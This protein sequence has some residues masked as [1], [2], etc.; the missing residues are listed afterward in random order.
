MS[1]R[2]ATPVGA[3]RK[4][5]NVGPVIVYRAFHYLYNSYYLYFNNYIPVVVVVVAVAVI[6]TINSIDQIQPQLL[7]IAQ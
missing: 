7:A 4:R 1:Q 6:V 5:C 2:L 3:K